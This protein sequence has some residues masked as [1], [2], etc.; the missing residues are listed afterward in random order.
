MYL[1]RGIATF[2]CLGAACNK[3]YIYT[4]H[5]YIDDKVNLSIVNALLESNNYESALTLLDD[6]Q[7]K[8]VSCLEEELIKWKT[9]S[10]TEERDQAFGHLLSAISYGFV[11]PENIFVELSDAEQVQVRE[12]M[13]SFNYKLDSELVEWLNEATA[14]DQ[15]A[16]EKWATARK[17]SDS[18]A[19][20]KAI[21]EVR[22]VDARNNSKL[23]RYVRKNGWP[24]I[25]TI[26]RVGGV[27]NLPPSLLVKH[28]DKSFNEFFLN[29]I[30]KAAEEGE[31]DWSVAEEVQRNIIIRFKNLDGFRSLNL[32]DFPN[33]TD[34][35]LLKIRAISSILINSPNL[36]FIL[37]PQLEGP[38]TLTTLE[39]I[40]EY[41]VNQGVNPEQLEISDRMQYENSI[42]WELYFSIKRMY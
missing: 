18:V 8:E 11:F 3:E 40:Y 2:L 34:R 38:L 27:L 15:S 24:G 16:R 20:K 36:K 29:A 33:M 5:Q 32:S 10:K 35:S 26:G 28:Y 21:E 39:D 7:C 12:A 14:A 30:I 37:H 23:K 31:E 6:N 42:P 9:I 13:R 25:K 17:S 4:Y 22:V 41:L 1:I 19:L